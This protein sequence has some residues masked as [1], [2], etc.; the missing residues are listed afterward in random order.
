MASRE[1]TGHASNARK[2][3]TAMTQLYESISRWIKDRLPRLR[4]FVVRYSKKAGQILLDQA[5]WVMVRFAITIL[6]LILLYLFPG[7]KGIIIQIY[8]ILSKF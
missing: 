4:D 1:S 7:L 8:D 2:E 5:K 3:E 6:L